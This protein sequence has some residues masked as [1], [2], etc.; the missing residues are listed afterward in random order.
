[1]PAVS[2]PQPH[3]QTQINSILCSVYNG[4]AAG[5][6]VLKRDAT[7]VLPAREAVNNP[8]SRY[9]REIGGFQ[10]L[11]AAKEGKIARQIDIG[12][13]K[14]ARIAGEGVELG[15]SGFCQA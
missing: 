15:D 12:E 11:T 7:D 1:M 8:V 13:M 10:I 2:L 5:D 9:L 3:T 6:N 4:I 14:I